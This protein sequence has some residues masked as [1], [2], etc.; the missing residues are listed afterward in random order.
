MNGTRS[1]FFVGQ[2]G[3]EAE[4]IDAESHERI[5]AV[6]SKQAGK[7]Y[8]PFSGRTAKTTS[9][10][11]QIEQAMDYWADKLRK[12]LDAARGKTGATEG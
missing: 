10:W 12:R 6:V 3:I 5:I 4:F 9:K 2:I 7:K 11:S 8:I 1:N